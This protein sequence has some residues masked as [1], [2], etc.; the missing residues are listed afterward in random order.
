MC[1][2]KIVIRKS[3]RFSLKLCTLYLFS[4]CEYY[5]NLDLPVTILLTLATIITNL[6][7]FCG[8]SCPKNFLFCKGNSQTQITWVTQNIYSSAWSIYLWVRI[9]YL[10]LYSTMLRRLLVHKYHMISISLLIVY[11]A[12]NDK[13]STRL[14]PPN[15]FH[16]MVCCV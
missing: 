14:L 1:V 8:R 12:S 10:I 15:L 2:S 16:W 5:F 3:K 13:T 4:T 9:I 11:Y 6:S 7:L